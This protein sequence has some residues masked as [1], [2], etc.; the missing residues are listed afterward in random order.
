MMTPQQ[1]GVLALYF[2]YLCV[3]HTKFV[4]SGEILQES[5]ISGCKTRPRHDYG[6]KTFHTVECQ[7]NTV[8]YVM[9][10]HTSLQ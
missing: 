10:L 6:S 1:T 8:Q 3:C 7:Y 9:I 2:V 5:C 4:G